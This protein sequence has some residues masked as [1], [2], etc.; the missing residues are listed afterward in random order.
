MPKLGL[1]MLVKPILF[2]VLLNF[3][4]D[5]IFKHSIPSRFA[6]LLKFSQS[7]ESLQYDHQWALSYLFERSM[8]CKL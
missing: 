3:V 6:V 7:K 4:E 8:I 2:Y 5:P 1:C